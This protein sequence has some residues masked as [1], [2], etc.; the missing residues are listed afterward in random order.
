[1]NTPTQN[2]ASAQKDYDYS[3]AGLP[4]DFDI[5]FEVAE[6]KEILQQ[7]QQPFSASKWHCSEYDF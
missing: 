6:Q 7:S 4:R 5:R 3:N 1:M 2:R